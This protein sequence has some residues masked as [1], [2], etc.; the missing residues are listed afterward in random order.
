[1]TTLGIYEKALPKNL[2]WKERL[3]MAKNLGFDFVEMS[4]DETDERLARLEWNADQRANVLE[5]IQET[6]IKILSICLSGHRRFPFGSRDEATREQALIIMQKAI[7][8]ASDLGIRT[9]QL[10]GYDVYYEKKTL[11]SRL[12]LIHI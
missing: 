9:I 5:S 6:G 2:S 11:S 8:F 3:M 12:S 7:D 4:I 1:M 10:A